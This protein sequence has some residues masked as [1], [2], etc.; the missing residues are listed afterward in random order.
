MESILKDVRYGFRMLLRNPGFTA[1][2]VLAITLG[3]GANTTTFSALDAT[4]FHPFS[5]PS[6]DRLGDALGSEPGAALFAR[7]GVARQLQRLA[8]RESIVRSGGRNQ[9]GPL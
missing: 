4:L 7:V 1:V 2:A 9:P 5:F 8:K 6:Q 3:I